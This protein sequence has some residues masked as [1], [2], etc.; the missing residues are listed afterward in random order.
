MEKNRETLSRARASGLAKKY[1]S[2]AQPDP[3]PCVV[4]HDVLSDYADEDADRDGGSHDA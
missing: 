3:F 1:K 4:G 2:S